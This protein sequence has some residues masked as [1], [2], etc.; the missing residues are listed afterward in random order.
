MI[1]ANN[2]SLIFSDKKLFND[3]NVKFTK[4]NCYGV[5]GA[6]GSGKSTFL[7]ILSG[8]LDSTTGDIII[9]KGK[10]LAVLK[11]DHFA[12]NEYSIL[13]TVIMGHTR[14]YEIIK[15]KER[16]YSKADFNDEDGLL[17]AELEA[18]FEELDGWNAEY[19]VQLLLNGLGVEEKNIETKMADIKSS[20]KVKIL[21]AQALF[22]NPDILLLDEPTNHLDFN[23][24]NWLENFLIDYDNT[25]IVVSH[26][27]HFLNKVCTHI[28]DI[29][30]ETGKLYVGNYDFW[31]K[32]SELMLKLMND[33]NKKKEE[34]IKELEAFIARFSANASKSKQATS[35]KKSLEKI[36]L[37]NITPSSRKYPFINFAIEKPL[38]KELLTVNGLSKTINGVKILNDI[39]FS[40]N[41]REKAVILSKNDLAAST[42]LQILSGNM[43]PDTGTIKWGSTVI[44]DYLGLNNE[45]FFKD[46]NLNLIDWLKQYSYDKTNTFIRGFLGRM[47]FSGDQPLKEIK[48]LSG[49]EKMRCMFSK[50]MLSGA[51]CLLLD[52]PI[53]Y[54]LAYA[55]FRMGLAPAQWTSSNMLGRTANP[56]N[57]RRVAGGSEP[58]PRPPPWMPAALCGGPVAVLPTIESTRALEPAHGPDAA[59]ALMRDTV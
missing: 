26:D 32:S 7:K 58:P 10:R 45:V 20:D 49:G 53:F 19:N 2:I 48:V 9:E 13:E 4:G 59:Q 18:E 21:L 11:Q 56:R 17:A 3:I 43:E 15:E 42:L 54:R 6:N 16:L 29:D 28:F 57:R 44:T 1:T 39:N 31:Q 30:R 40:M 46:C 34:R 35:R 24:I 47:L 22:N 51:N 25:I 36:E 23:A 55:A 33:S 38:G 27:R 37:D 41:G 8:D 50:L 5:I 52:Q 14:L 12:Y